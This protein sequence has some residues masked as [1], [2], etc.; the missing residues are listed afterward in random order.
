[1]TESAEGEDRPFAVVTGAS[2]G[3]GAVV[4]RVL[5]GSGYDLLLTARD[6]AALRA[7]ARGLGS[8]GGAIDVVS[9][10]VTD[11]RHRDRLEREVS[12]HRG[13]D[14]LVNN[15]AILGPTPLPA[16][17]ELDPAELERIYR[18]NVVA[19]VALVRAFLPALTARRGLVVNISSDAAIGG[20]P[21]WGGYG[22]SKAALD[23]VS[24]TLAQELRAAGVSVVA[25]DPGE[26]RTPGAEPAF[27]REEF[28]SRPPPEVTVPFWAWL[29]GQP[30]SE[31]TGHRYRAQ[32]EHWGVR[33]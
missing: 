11:P 23:L 2:R 17:T 8:W 25:V 15:A 10:D 21:G 30:R 1:M 14:L 3:L 18:V 6:E 29:L 26:L 24:L 12:G 5:A 33:A 9:G 7:V 16:L 28:Q 20:Y 31:V 19:P 4:A 13:L 27:S 32:S 22:A